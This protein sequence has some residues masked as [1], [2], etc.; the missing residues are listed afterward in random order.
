[1]QERFVGWELGIILLFATLAAVSALVAYKRLKRAVRELELALTIARAEREHAESIIGR[2]SEKVTAVASATPGD[3]SLNRPV[4]PD[5]A[6][7]EMVRKLK[8]DFISSVSHELRTPLASIKAYVEMLI[9]GEAEDEKA[10][11]DFYDVIQNEANRLSRLI[12][13]ILNVSKIESGLVQINRQ[14]QSLS[15]VVSDAMEAIA[16]QARAKQIVLEEKLTDAAYEALVDKELIFQAI[17]NL[18]SNAIKFT[19]LNGRVTVETAV[20]QDRRAVL[21]RV[22]DTGAGIPSGDVPYIFEKFYKLQ[23]SARQSQGTGLGLALV[24]HIVELAHQGKVSVRS[25]VG[26]GS[27]FEIELPLHAPQE[28]PKA[29]GSLP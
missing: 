18:L 7:L 8:N 1:V 16:P 4:P 28:A 20:D 23:A 22:T 27:C 9:D 19:P 6:P 11:R 21:V 25:E 2:L 17:L 10:K 14:P 15:P 26:N 3:S 13:N 29:E 24:R 12:D 5:A